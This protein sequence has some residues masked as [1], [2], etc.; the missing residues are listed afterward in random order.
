MFDYPSFKTGRSGKSHRRL[1]LRRI[2]PTVLMPLLA[3]VPIGCGT[4]GS[5]K[6]FTRP[7]VA[8]KVLMLLVQFRM[9]EAI[10]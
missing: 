2:P 4:A 8:P 7:T 6:T 9:F 5:L 10:L 1:P 3:T